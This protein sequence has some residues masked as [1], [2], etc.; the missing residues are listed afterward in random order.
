MASS[1]RSE[2]RV[3]KPPPSLNILPLPTI[4]ITITTLRLRLSI[5]T[6]RPRDPAF[7]SVPG[8][9]PGGL[10]GPCFLSHLAEMMI[11]MRVGRPSI[12]LLCLLVLLASAHLSYAHAHQRN[13]PQ[14][15]PQPQKCSKLLTRKEWR[16]LTNG[17]KADW[18]GAVKVRALLPSPFRADIAHVM[19]C[20]ASIRHQRLSLAKDQTVLEGKRS[21]YDDFSYSH[22]LMEPSSH[23]SA[24]FL[25]WRA[26]RPFLS[27]SRSFPRAHAY[28]APQTAGSSTYSTPPS[29]RAAGTTGRHH[30]GTGRAI[31]QTC[32]TRPSSRIRPNTGWAGQE[33]AVPPPRPTASSPLAL[34][35]H[36]PATLSSPGLSPTGC[37]G[38]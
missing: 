16:T 30:T 15:P 8:G 23:R 28:V 17:E 11:L 34:L 22:A 2:K 33:T 26:S 32:S 13:E 19:Q 6:P 20:L 27:P 7:S 9:L 1:S 35:P 29:A 10:P 3:G 36:P 31:T 12:L 5:A 14:S 25:P 18:V 38:T 37:G 4:I 21:L 24:Y